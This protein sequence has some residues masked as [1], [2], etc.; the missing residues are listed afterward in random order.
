M[1]RSIRGL[2][3]LFL[4][5]CSA[6]FG[7]GSVTELVQKGDE[8]WLERSTSLEQVGRAIGL[9]EA[10]AHSDP[11]NVDAAYRASMGYYYLG[12][13]TDE[14]T[15]KMDLFSKGKD[16]GLEAV[17]RDPRSAQAHYWYG[18]NMGSY[19]QTRGK[20]KTLFLVGPLKEAFQEVVRLD[21]TCYYG[22]GYRALGKLYFELPGFAGGDKKKAEEYLR[23]SLKVEPC[24]TLTLLY[25]AELLADSHRDSEARDV[26]ERLM[27]CRPPPGFEREYRQDQAEGKRLLER[28]ARDGPP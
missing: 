6:A 20:L 22:G 17:R 16:W 23:M 27:N 1:M 24:Y 21:P 7:Q 10:A 2:T 8:L 4:L 25:L 3:L 26:L 28:L 13:F 14:P 19:G 9:W 15:Q 5:G 12:R 18:V 11:H